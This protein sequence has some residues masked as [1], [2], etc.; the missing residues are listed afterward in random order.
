MKRSLCTS[1]LTTVLMCS[2]QA[3]DGQL[4]HELA[5]E[6]CIKTDDVGACMQGFGFTCD[7]LASP[8]TAIGAFRLS[9]NAPLADGRLHFVQ[10]QNDTEEWTIER[11]RSYFPDSAPYNI[12]PLEGPLSNLADYI[13]DQMANMTLL[14]SGTEETMQRSRI[15]FE[16]RSGSAGDTMAL[17]AICGTELDGE[18][19]DALVGDIRSHCGRLLRRNIVRF[20]QPDGDS[21]YRVY[22]MDETT[23][24]TTRTIVGAD[25]DALLL[26]GRYLFP[27]NH[28]PCR[29]ISDCCS[30]DGSM[31][32]E[33]CREPSVTEHEAIVVCLERGLRIRTGRFHECLREQDV[34]VGCELQSDGSSLCY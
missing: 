15:V 11:Q 25:L 7:R 9:C 17:M 29:F 5:A 30:R 23:W 20:A 3:L 22:G 1:L 6:E 13:Q 27:S 31:Y 2:A 10:M 21:P 28:T 14:H 16:V 26:E 12:E 8:Q 24:T 34:P 33:S 18:P 32:L 4:P 19:S